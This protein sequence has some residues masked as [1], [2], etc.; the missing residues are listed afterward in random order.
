MA[1]EKADSSPGQLINDDNGDTDLGDFQ[2]VL[3]NLIGLAFFLGDFIGDLGAGFPPLPAVLTGLILTSAG[4]YS[5]K[6]L[7]AQ[8]APTLSSVVPA[9][10]LP[11]ATV[12]VFGTG[13]VIPKAVAGTEDDQLPTVTVGGHTA[14]ATAD[15]ALG[16]DRLT[17]TV[18][19]EAKPGSAPIRVVCADGGPASQPGGADRLAFEVL[20]PVAA[21]PQVNGER[22]V[23]PVTPV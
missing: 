10:A 11:E 18:P 9:A 23:V 5:A 3:F 21:E 4:G 1:S 17:V 13:L 7:V 12:V 22:T 16:S 8:T 20:A 15:R 19:K 2:Y 6:K 14:T